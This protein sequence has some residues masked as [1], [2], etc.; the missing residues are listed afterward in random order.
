M[1]L[2]IQQSSVNARGDQ[3]DQQV[4]SR[5]AQE[6]AAS[7]EA[8]RHAE[9]GDQ[10]YREGDLLGGLLLP[11]ASL[12]QRCA[13][14]YASMQ[15][16][17]ANAARKAALTERLTPE[18]LAPIIEWRG[19]GA[20]LSGR[21]VGY[22]HRASHWSPAPYLNGQNQVQITQQEYSW[23]TR[24]PPTV[25]GRISGEDIGGTR[26]Y[27]RG[28]D[29]RGQ[30]FVMIPANGGFVPVKHG[31][32]PQLRN[33]LAPVGQAVYPIVFDRHG[34]RH[35]AYPRVNYAAHGFQEV[36]DWR[37]RTCWWPR[38]NGIFS[39]RPAEVPDSHITPLHTERRISRIPPPAINQTGTAVARGV[40]VGVDLVLKV[41][42]VFGGIYL[43]GPSAGAAIAVGA[44][45][46]TVA[47]HVVR[48]YQDFTGDAARL[49][50]YHEQVAARQER[51]REQ[52]G[53]L[54]NQNRQDE[55]L[56]HAIQSDEASLD[57]ERRPG[58]AEA[59]AESKREH[60]MLA[61]RRETAIAEARRQA[62]E[63][64]GRIRPEHKG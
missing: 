1:S 47:D 14:I 20:A 45:Q 13:V 64:L 61:A 56:V 27:F 38:G 17:I 23:K 15:T 26:H 39:P 40:G 24:T 53:N 36:R 8:E 9:R 16:R 12:G 44:S 2:T 57:P 34:C 25:N 4:Q 30:P 10:A 29:Q 31:G 33:W 50:L 32:D 6:N 42:G 22:E 37:G 11:L 5:P 43:A 63:N 46:L 18:G 7:T 3:L 60:K 51:V 59:R 41:G 62:L 55:I 21:V 35:P 49:Q 52:E 54:A 19:N 48:G 28:K 58:A